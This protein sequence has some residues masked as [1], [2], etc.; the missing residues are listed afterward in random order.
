MLGALPELS[1]F[2]FA[3]CIW[4]MCLYYSHLQMS[5]FVVSLS[6]VIKDTQLNKWQSRDLS[7]GITIYLPKETKVK[8]TLPVSLF[9]LCHQ[10]LSRWIQQDLNRKIIITYHLPGKTPSHCCPSHFF[11]F[12]GLQSYKCQ[13]VLPWIKGLTLGLA[14]QCTVGW[15]RLTDLLH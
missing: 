9:F 15:A 6:N 8:P 11:V 13:P 10:L 7:P 3:T 12:T 4:T 14:E 5:K 1:H 2:M